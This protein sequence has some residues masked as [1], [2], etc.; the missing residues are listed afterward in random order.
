MLTAAQIG[1]V[2]VLTA[3]NKAGDESADVTFTGEAD[4][5]GNIDSSNA[6]DMVGFRI[7][8]NIQDRDE[9]SDR[10]YLEPICNDVI[11]QYKDREYTIEQNPGW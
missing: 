8:N 5:K 4:D 10:N 1:T 2:K 9:F 6:E 7:P 3:P 11:N